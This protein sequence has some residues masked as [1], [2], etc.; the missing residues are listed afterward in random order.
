MEGLPLCLSGSTGK[1]VHERLAEGG[2]T[3]V[4]MSEGARAEISA[5]VR[6]GLAEAREAGRVGGRPP[7]IDAALC[8]LMRADYE[9]GMSADK[10]S[11]KYGKDRA[12]I[13]RAFRRHDPGFVP[14]TRR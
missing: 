6:E 9:G 8:G 14:I 10:L 13:L 3:M 5:A 7:A 11:A 2:T 4:R 12:T 1:A